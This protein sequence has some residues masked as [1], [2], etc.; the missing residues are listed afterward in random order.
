MG[1][2]GEG[3]SGCAYIDGGEASR[4][5]SSIVV[6]GKGRKGRKGEKKEKREQKSKFHLQL[7]PD[8]DKGKREVSFPC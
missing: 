4:R 5:I 3:W 6:E 8:R 2:G 1:E 7:S